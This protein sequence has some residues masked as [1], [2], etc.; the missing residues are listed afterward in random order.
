MEVA[1]DVVFRGDGRAIRTI[2]VPEAQAEQAELA[3]ALDDLIGRHR[4]AHA[5]DPTDAAPWEW[6]WFL[7]ALDRGEVSPGTYYL[8]KPRELKAEAEESGPES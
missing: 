2:E 1:I 6:P 8:Y 5:N 7:A 3:R 4:F